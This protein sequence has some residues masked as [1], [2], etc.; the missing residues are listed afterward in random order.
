MTQ[1]EVLSWL[2]TLPYFAEPNVRLRR[3]MNDTERIEVIQ[4]LLDHASTD[5]MVE[6]DR[7]V[8]VEALAYLR[9]D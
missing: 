2:E 5:K 6:D 1:P 4:D 3:C 9:N 7:T 8:C